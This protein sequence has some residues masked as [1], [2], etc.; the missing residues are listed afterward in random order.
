MKY[1]EQARTRDKAAAGRITEQ[2]ETSRHGQEGMLKAGGSRDR[3][4]TRTGAGR[5]FKQTVTVK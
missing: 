5:G 4:K 1:K 2:T 3:K